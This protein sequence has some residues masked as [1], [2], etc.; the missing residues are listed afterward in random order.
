MK[1]VELIIDE[2]DD[3]SG[4]DAISVVESPAIE[5]NFIALSEQKQTFAKID[6][7]KRILMGAILVPNKTIYRRD[8]NGDEYYIY[9]SKETIRK[10]AELY[11]INANQSNTTYEHFESV[12]GCTLIESWFV[13]DETIDKSALYNLGL[14]AGTWCGTMKINNDTIWN[15]YV[16]TGKVKGFSIEG[17]FADKFEAKMSKDM[18][19]DEIEAGLDLLEIALKLNDTK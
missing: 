3:L 15:D 9:F 13:E 5:S 2:T 18:Y 7:E 10:A 16:K 12:T 1:I 17:Y 19:L 14:S 4:V 6:E 8:P 11:F